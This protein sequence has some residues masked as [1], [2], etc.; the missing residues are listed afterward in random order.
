MLHPGDLRFD[1][2]EPTHELFA[3][4]AW[5]GGARIM[6]QYACWPLPLPLVVP[7]G[8]CF[9]SKFVWEAELNAPVNGIYVF[10]RYRKAAYQ[11]AYPG[12]ALDGCSPWLYI[13]KDSNLRKA[14]KRGTVVFPGHSTHHLNA[15]ANDSEYASFLSS[16]PANEGPVV[17]CAYWRDIELN[18]HRPYLRQGLEVVSAG[19]MYDEEFLPRLANLLH[20]AE[21]VR[22]NAIGSHALYAAAAGCKVVI[23]QE[24]LSI[25]CSEEDRKR[26]GLEK[27]DCDLEQKLF[28]T[29]TRGVSQNEQAAMSL[30]LLGH[31]HKKS[32]VQLF[33]LLARVSLA[34]GWLIRCGLYH[35]LRCK[36]SA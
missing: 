16:L 30:D 10:P 15:T 29:F 24:F 17:V 21:Y 13:R 6:K 2:N 11:A 4:N 18:R 14:K 22:T 36:I 3:P 28:N 20:G 34:R 8:V 19:H 5:Y 7:H 31:R 25:D 35:T 26:W 9:S 23:D 32:R 12:T 1:C 33:A 27:N